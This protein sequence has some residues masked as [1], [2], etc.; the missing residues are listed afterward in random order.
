MKHRTP[1]EKKKLSLA[2]DRRNVYGE[3]PHGARKSIPLQKKLRNRA[4]R[5][6]QEAQLPTGPVD[7][8]KKRRTGLTLRCTR[9]HLRTGAKVQT[10]HLA[11]C[12]QKSFG[13]ARIQKPVQSDAFRLKLTYKL[14][15]W[16]ARRFTAP[17]LLRALVQQSRTH[18]LSKMWSGQSGG[19]I[20]LFHFSSPALSFAT[21]FG[22]FAA[23]S[24]DSPGSASRSYN[25]GAC[26]ALRTSL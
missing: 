7:L 23:R 22:S 14:S 10:S 13:D 25:S 3:A 5:H 15:E 24:C 6:S 11:R 9:K 17:L 16:R 12:S 21:S 19:T 18:F 26:L 2:K 8:R 20:S 4:N 1:Q